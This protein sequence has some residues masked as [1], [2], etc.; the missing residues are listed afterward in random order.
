MGNN[1]SNSI[2]EGEVHSEVDFINN[3]NNNSGNKFQIY[4]KIQ[5]RSIFIFS[6]IFYLLDVIKLNLGTVFNFYRR[7]EIWIIL[8]YNPIKEESK[9]IKDEYITLSE[10][11]FGIF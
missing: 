4:F 5:V 11:M 2:L 9:N 10:K 8:F 1:I 3:N 6:N 7:K